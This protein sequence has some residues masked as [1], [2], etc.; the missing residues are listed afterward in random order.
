[1][2]DGSLQVFH[3]VNVRQA[4][5]YAEKFPETKVVILDVRI[6]EFEPYDSHETGSGLLTG[7]RLFTDLQQKLPGAHF[8]FKTWS[9]HDHVTRLIPDYQQKLRNGEISGPFDP[10]DTHLQIEAIRDLI[11][12]TYESRPVPPYVLIVHG[13]ATD[14]IV[15]LKTLLRNEVWPRKGLRSARASGTGETQFSRSL[16]ISRGWSTLVFVLA[17]PDDQ[18]GSEWRARQKRH[19]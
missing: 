8:R 10:T 3:A 6:E 16:N 5:D 11:R 13:H 4:L 15:L 17:T 9:D 14:Q 12:Y 7:V 2:I 19:I 1:M 18:C